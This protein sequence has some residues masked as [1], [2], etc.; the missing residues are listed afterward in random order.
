[1]LEYTEEACSREDELDIYHILF[2]GTT[3]FVE[4]NFRGKSRFTRKITVTW[5]P[6][7]CVR[8]NRCYSWKRSLFLRWIA[9]FFFSL[10]N[11]SGSVFLPVLW[12]VAGNGHDNVSAVK[13]NQ[14]VLVVLLSWC[15]YP[16]RRGVSV[17]WVAVLSI[18][19][20]WRLY[21]V[22]EKCLPDSH[23]L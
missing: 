16:G 11:G 13:K 4:K 2:V 1:V 23:P 8:R 22:G 12:V 14:S 17:G 18:K 9:V 20:L 15:A 7:R 21:P 3:C 5:L 10:C 19:P 6:R